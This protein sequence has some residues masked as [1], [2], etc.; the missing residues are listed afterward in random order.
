[1]QDR[2][3]GR[4]H[5]CGGDSVFARNFAGHFDLHWRLWE[6]FEEV[7]RHCKRVGATVMIERPR[8]CSYW[9]EPRI[10]GFWN[11]LGF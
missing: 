9:S 11:D 10:S 7:A 4:A 3:I 1:M 8:F 2:N 5:A 6:G